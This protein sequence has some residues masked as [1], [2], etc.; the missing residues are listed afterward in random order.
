MKIL[1]TGL[2]GL[3]GT[4]VVDTLK[5]EFSFINLSLETGVDIT[6]PKTLEKAFASSDAPWVFHFAART[7]VDIIENEKNLKVQS[8]AWKVNVIATESIASL[9]KKPRSICCIYQLIMYFQEERQIHR[10][11]HSGS[12]SFMR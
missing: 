10:R 11:R 9:C 8:P 2:S 1:G 5:Q 3:L 6:D 7:D 12:E 4:Q